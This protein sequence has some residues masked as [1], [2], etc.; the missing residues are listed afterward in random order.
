MYI[1]RSITNLASV[2]IVHIKKMGSF[3]T[4]KDTNNQ[5][6]PFFVTES[7]GKLELRYPDVFVCYKTHNYIFMW[8]FYAVFAF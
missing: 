1:T 6:S 3:T 2:R 8:V 7:V 4:L 5:Y